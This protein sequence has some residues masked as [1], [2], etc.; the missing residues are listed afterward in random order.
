MF[1]ENIT[2][3]LPHADFDMVNVYSDFTLILQVVKMFLVAVEY[4]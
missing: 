3:I 4:A 1:W 2:E